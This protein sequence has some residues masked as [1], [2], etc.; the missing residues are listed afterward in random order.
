M[1]NVV[2][3]APRF[4]CAGF[5]H[6]TR[7]HGRSIVNRVLGARTIHST[8]RRTLL[9]PFDSWTRARQTAWS[10]Y[11]IPPQ[12]GSKCSRK[13]FSGGTTPQARQRHLPKAATQ[14]NVKER[15]QSRLGKNLTWEDYDPEGGLPLPSGD[16]SRSKIIET[17]GHGMS[18]E[19]GNWILRSVNYRRESGSLIDLG[20]DFPEE[21]QISKEMAFKA[22]TYLREIQ[23]DFDEN[24]AGAAWADMEAQ[25]LEAK[26]IERSEAVG[27]YKRIPEEESERKVP[28]VYGDGS[29]LVAVR[30]AGEARYREEQRKKE[31][32]EKER[33]EASMREYGLKPDDKTTSPDSETTNAGRSSDGP[34]AMRRSETS[35]QQDVVLQQPTQKAW[36]QP[37]ERKPWVKYYEEQAT[38][39][40]ENIVP[41]MSFLRRTGPSALVVLATLAFCVYLH[42]NY[43]P[44]SR[45][46]RLLP[47]LPPALATISAI[48]ATNFVIAIAFRMPPL[49]RTMNKWFLSV[50][51]LPVP[52]AMLTS[53][54]THQSFAHLSINMVLLWAFGR[55]RTLI[56]HT[57]VSLS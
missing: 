30:K 41:Q 10:R 14:T 56:Y 16:A 23:P 38:L 53:M 17:F 27:L 13:C 49:W 55:Y 18:I 19:A 4:Q 5:G 45:S 42:E 46:A 11:Q 34:N 50:P 25:K 51:A 39:V 48:V 47:D 24:E 35:S 44:P 1:N 12:N 40:K 54:F 20:I 32:L 6:S 9:A 21:T 3:I 37:V 29:V 22:L 57:A 31:E 2:L 28:D 15:A 52:T 43:T 26:Y 33:E 7:L 8:N 36:L